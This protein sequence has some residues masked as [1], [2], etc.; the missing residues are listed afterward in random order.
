MS[1]T[2]LPPGVTESMIDEHAEGHTT[3]VEY[4]PPC[5]TCGR[6]FDQHVEVYVVDDEGNDGFDYAC[7][8]GD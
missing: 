2:N 7:P 3:F 4:D 1:L 5:P 8:K 6:L